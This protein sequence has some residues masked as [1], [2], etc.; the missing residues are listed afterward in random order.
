MAKRTADE[1]DTGTDPA[2]LEHVAFVFFRMEKVAEL[3]RTSLPY[4]TVAQPPRTT[5]APRGRGVFEH[6]GVKLLAS[7]VSIATWLATRCCSADLL[8]CVLFII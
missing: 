3:K 5:R 7:V 1:R 8:L 2:E 6:A 4:F